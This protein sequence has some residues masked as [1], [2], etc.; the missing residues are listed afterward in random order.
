VVRIDW[1]Y[2]IADTI[3]F[4]KIAPYEHFQKETL[5][6]YSRKDPSYRTGKFFYISNGGGEGIY[7]SKFQAKKAA[8]KLRRKGR[9]AIPAEGRSLINRD[10][11]DGIR[12]FVQDLRQELLQQA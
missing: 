8:A 12:R 6:K 7:F 5:M 11:I 1:P 4:P 10:N 9:T 3:N 2:T